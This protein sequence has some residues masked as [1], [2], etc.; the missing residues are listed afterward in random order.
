M[1]QIPYIETDA[2]VTAALL[3]MLFEEL[4]RK[5]A[6]ALDEHALAYVL[7]APPNN[8][9]VFDT[10]T[11]RTA[12]RRFMTNCFAFG[13]GRDV[14]GMWTDAAYDHAPYADA[15]AGASVW[16]EAYATGEGYSAEL[17]RPHYNVEKRWVR[18]HGFPAGGEYGFFRDSLE[19]HRV[20]FTP[21]D[22]EP[23]SYWIR[24]LNDFGGILRE[25]PCRI[26]A[27]H[28]ADLIF[29][30]VDDYDFPANY[31][32]F[33]FFRIHNANSSALTVRF[34]KTDG[35][36]GYA[37]TVPAYGSQCVRR[38][39]VDGTYTAG[40]K[41][42]Q[43][44][45]PGDVHYYN[46]G[47]PEGISNN[48]VSPQILLPFVQCVLGG[49][50]I[51][52]TATGVGNGW[53]APTVMLDPSVRAPLPARAS[54][55]YGDPDAPET[56]I[57]DLLH[58]RGAFWDIGATG[59]G[60]GGN[61]TVERTERQFN[62]YSTI[63]GDMAAQGITVT[64]P[65]SDCVLTAVSDGKQHDAVSVG[66]N[67]F[68][69]G[70]GQ[71]QTPV[72]D[73]LTG[74]TLDRH[75]PP[76]WFYP[77]NV[78]A[79][80]A[81]I[82]YYQLA[83]DG[84]TLGAYV[85]VSVDSKSLTQSVPAIDGSQPCPILPHQTTAHQVKTMLGIYCGDTAHATGDGGESEFSNRQF[86]LSSSGLWLVA[87]HVTLPSA[88]PANAAYLWPSLAGYAS[89]PITSGTTSAFG[90]GFP[91]QA[92]SGQRKPYVWSY[93]FSVEGITEKRA[94]HFDGYGWSNDEDWSGTAYA[95][96]TGPFMP[97][98][99]QRIYGMSTLYSDG[100]Y[101]DDFDE[102][103]G[104]TGSD[105]VYN[106]SKLEL[107]PQI[108]A[109]SP[110]NKAG[111]SYP[112]GYVDF[113]RGSNPKYRPPGCIFNSDVLRGLVRNFIEGTSFSLGIAQWF[114]NN[115]GRLLANTLLG[116]SALVYPNGANGDGVFSGI[117][118]L[119]HR[120]PCA[121]E[122]YNNMAA[123][124]NSI[125]R[126]RPLNFNDHG[127]FPLT[128]NTRQRPVPSSG[129]GLP[130]VT[131]A[132]YMQVVPADQYSTFG[133]SI[134]GQGQFASAITA[135]GLMRSAMDL[136]SSYQ[137]AHATMTATRAVHWN[138]RTIT[139]DR[140]TQQGISTYLHEV[141]FSVA[142]SD[143]SV[144]PQVETATPLLNVGT[145]QWC[146]ISEVKAY[147]EA[148][149][150][151]FV[152]HT[153]GTPLDLQVM[154]CAT[155]IEAV[156]RQDAGRYIYTN[157]DFRAEPYSGSVPVNLTTTVQSKYAV[158]VEGES[159]AEWLGV[160]STNDDRNRVA[161]VET[162]ALAPDV[163]TTRYPV[164]SIVIQLATS[165]PFRRRFSGTSKNMATGDAW[166]TAFML[167]DHS[168]AEIPRGHWA[169]KMPCDYITRTP[170]F[171][172]TSE[173]A[174]WARIVHGASVLPFQK[175]AASGVVVMEAFTGDGYF[176]QQAG[177]RIVFA[178]D[179][180]EAV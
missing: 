23:A 42:F 111:L 103:D 99:Y 102:P 74:V 94:L 26:R 73:L 27:L 126:Y 163:M 44:F 66:T 64:R 165:E 145:Y 75:M 87:D 115:R 30:G 125:T 33:N 172:T 32:R 98:G 13:I 104:A 123:K 52:S 57:G 100:R 67:L 61:P 119:F 84:N 137:S 95:N 86:I 135:A 153:H 49:W 174:A 56:L 167:K 41:Y 77:F 176:S 62:G 82:G 28:H 9:T 89:G 127:W 39:A 50:P 10:S 85:P 14:A 46:Q 133:G 105:V 121:V 114:K 25:F 4:D 107:R 92:N 168:S 43:R 112:S 109:L 96:T 118:C 161:L 177:R 162:D 113:E 70:S 16:T 69:T 53:I 60:I 59:L 106:D 117:T 35:G 21:P 180:T 173:V 179:N 36:I 81:A 142:E 83:G 8:L 31:N 154:E 160:R 2:P 120:I 158:F 24:E 122:H 40:F 171:S 18:M 63:D 38:T 12:M 91:G 136:P 152:H 164:Y 150:W 5:T 29:E 141:T 144:G 51:S 170:D 101:H 149:G 34:R 175:V 17:F 88:P 19:A 15:V 72:R 124:V 159:T 130:G 7:V 139:D 68:T 79:G 140:V 166:V 146:K 156:L 6:L 1:P 78:S 157:R 45:L 22:G 3:N 80:T 65:G 134:T 132:E 143:F 116:D 178:T 55:L 37:A 131:F 58:H 11:T 138:T 97:P 155:G 90:Q 169:I 20:T 48:V 110:I 54:A 93:A 128:G 148:R 108:T 76:R 151:L 47:A 129:F 71:I 147:A